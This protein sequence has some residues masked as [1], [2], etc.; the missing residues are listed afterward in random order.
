MWQRPVSDRVNAS[1]D[2]MEATLPDAH[3]NLPL[4][5]TALAKLAERDNAPLL[6]GQ[7][8]HEQIRSTGGFSTYA[9]T[10]PPSM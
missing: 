8:R 5:E 7:S 3:G 6:S 4:R 2:A 9:V 10:N 1:V